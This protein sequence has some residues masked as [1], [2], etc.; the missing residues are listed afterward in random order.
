RLYRSAFA[1]VEIFVKMRE[2]LSTN[3]DILLKLEQLEKQTMQNTYDVQT[4]LDY[5][6]QFLVPVEQVERRMI[7]FQR[8]DEQ[9]RSIPS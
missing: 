6:K 1:I 9:G 8:D 3:K 2:M 4:V 5:I 7:G